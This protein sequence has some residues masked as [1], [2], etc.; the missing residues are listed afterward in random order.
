MD[1]ISVLRNTDFPPRLVTKVHVRETEGWRTAPWADGFAF[2]AT[3][4]PVDSL[5]TLARVLE[6][7]RQDPHTC[8]VRGKPLRPGV[9]TYKRYKAREGEPATYA[10]AAHRW[11]MLDVDAHMMQ[12]AE[13]L[14]SRPAEVLKAFKATLPEPWR[15]AACY[16][17]ASASAGI[18]PGIRAH[19]WFWL[20][21]AIEDDEAKAIASALHVRYNVDPNLY[22]PVQPHFTADPVFKGASD[23]MSERTGRI[24]GTAEVALPLDTPTLKDILSAQKQLTKACKVLVETPEGKR[25]VRA[26]GIAKDLGRTSCL[27]DVTVIKS[28]HDAAIAQGWDPGRT[29]GHLENGLAEGRAQRGEL[30]THPWRKGLKTD[31]AGEILS[32]PDNLLRVVQQHPAL[33]GAFELQARAQEI[34]IRR[35]LPWRPAGKLKDGDVLKLQAW[36]SSELN[37]K[38]SPQIAKALIMT[39]AED[40][41]FDPFADYLNG[42][43]WDGTPRLSALY[44][45]FEVTPSLYAEKTFRAWLISAVARTFAPGCQVD[46]MLVLCGPQGRYKSSALKTLVP[47]E[48][49]FATM[50]NTSGNGGLHKDSLA[51]IHGPV[52]VCVEEMAA[53]KNKDA[54]TIKHFITERT[55]R[56]RPSYGLV[57]QNYPRTN[58]FAGTS[59]FDTFLTDPTGGRRFWPHTVERSISVKAIEAN[60]DQLWAEAVHAY[61]QGE[62]HYLTPA[63]ERECDLA[64]VQE[65]A[66]IKSPLEHELEKVLEGKEEITSESL[67]DALQ[68]DLQAQMRNSSWM[69]SAMTAL[70]WKSTRKGKARTRVWVRS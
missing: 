5:D 63:E 6:S 29:L 46:H 70:G 27:D 15:S 9:S 20:S 11:I 43:E 25:A 39:E 13:N 36:F 35:E 2:T 44:R 40:N 57:T 45:L 8:V 59:N 67:R 47:H 50:A 28:L 19:L 69:A 30:S 49:E 66:R 33:M 24:D 14:V 60:R 62:R 12:G 53:F 10:P 56:F 52:I 41:A 42:L 48:D 38:A 3:E 65:S 51:H 34:H 7:I 16:W 54:D 64:S 55:D 17:H 4:E 21:R 32:T 31:D 23:P 68:W 58:V 1:F 18:K 22:Q 61:K 26:F 37:L